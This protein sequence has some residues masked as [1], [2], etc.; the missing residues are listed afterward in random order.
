MASSG[1]C[2]TNVDLSGFIQCDRIPG[3][4]YLKIHPVPSSL[5]VL[6]AV[7]YDTKDRTSHL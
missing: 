6:I 7:G 4:T 2:L 3:C 5:P 1:L